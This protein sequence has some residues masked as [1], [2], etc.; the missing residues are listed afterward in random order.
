MLLHTVLLNYFIY[1]RVKA[2][3]ILLGGTIQVTP[4]QNWVK[5]IFIHL[6]RKKVSFMLF[7]TDPQEK[8]CLPN[9][10]TIFD[11]VIEKYSR[12]QHLSQSEHLQAC[13]TSDFFFWLKFLVISPPSLT[14]LRFPHTL[15]MNTS[16]GKSNKMI[17]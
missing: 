12:L 5:A 2:S 9:W 13:K 16:L 17:A 1:S 7:T 6:I 8:T 10:F 14:T 11:M 3:Y 15:S 4:S